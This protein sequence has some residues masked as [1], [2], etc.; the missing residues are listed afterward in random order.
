MQTGDV[1]RTVN[2][3][4]VQGLSAA[5]VIRLVKG[6]PGTKVVLGLD[7]LIS[8]TGHAA[9][10]SEQMAAAVSPVRSVTPVHQEPPPMPS[11][12]QQTH[13]QTPQ[14]AL[15]SLQL[16]FPDPFQAI[17]GQPQLVQPQPMHLAPPEQPMQPPPPPQ[18]KDPEPQPRLQQQVCACFKCACFK[19]AASTNTPFP[20]STPQ[21]SCPAHCPLCAVYVPAA[22]WRV[23]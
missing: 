21:S 2:S 16:P 20:G 15:P 13:L 10:V 4:D 1:L 17:Q 6:I 23:P 7:V 18:N 19:C 12:P 22:Q 14:E 11:P 8:E 5:E 3:T 9:S